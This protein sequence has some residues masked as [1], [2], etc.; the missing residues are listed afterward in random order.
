MPSSDFCL[1]PRG[2]VIQVQRSAI[3]ATRRQVPWS[4]RERAGVRGS[5]WGREGRRRGPPPDVLPPKKIGGELTVRQRPSD[6]SALDTS[7]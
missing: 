3:S 6:A 4:A 5:P 2:V 1:I 7:F